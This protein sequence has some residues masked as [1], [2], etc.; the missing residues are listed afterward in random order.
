M[1]ITCMRWV[2]VDFK[3]VCVPYV[4]KYHIYVC[5]YGKSIN[6]LSI[7][8]VIYHS[9]KQNINEYYIHTVGQ[10]KL[11]IVSKQCACH[12]SIN[13]IYICGRPINRLSINT[14]IYH[15][16]KQNS[17]KYHICGRS[18]RAMN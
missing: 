6:R 17:N 1:N 16:S 14:I 8:T 18:V 7:N 5:V 4:N 13:I 9:S 2:S 12:M 10:C 3:T 15:S 11:Q